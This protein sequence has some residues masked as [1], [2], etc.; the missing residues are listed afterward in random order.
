MTLMGTTRRRRRSYYAS[1]LRFP[2]KSSAKIHA[3]FVLAHAEL[4]AYPTSIALAS[5]LRQQAA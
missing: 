2:R 5:G 1:R 3:V 4:F